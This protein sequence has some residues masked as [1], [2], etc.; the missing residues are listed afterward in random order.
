MRTKS[1][2]RCLVV[3]ICFYQIVF[4]SQTVENT[5]DHWVKVLSS[6]C[7]FITENENIHTGTA[8]IHTPN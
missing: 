1:L 2:V 4:E 5:E 7:V 6:L 8:M 3:C